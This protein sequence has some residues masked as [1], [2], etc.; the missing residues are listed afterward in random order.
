MQL[1]CGSTVVS[2]SNS[3]L[4]DQ[5]FTPKSYHIKD[6]KNGT[7]HL[8]IW[9]QKVRL[10]LESQTSIVIGGLVPSYSFHSNSICVAMDYKKQRLAP[11]YAT[12][13]VGKNFD[14]DFDLIEIYFLTYILIISF[15]AHQ[16]S[17]KF[18]SFCSNDQL[19]I[20]LCL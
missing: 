11:P 10:D 6:C 18:I 17:I 9:C 20:I 7:C 8:L 2:A 13:G 12:F 14:F 4:G 5:G 15:T 19:N 3:Q 1:R 16:P